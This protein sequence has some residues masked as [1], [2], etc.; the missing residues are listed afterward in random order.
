MLGSNKEDTKIK[1]SPED[2]DKSYWNKWYLAVLFFLIVQILIF[3]F[4]TQ[5]FN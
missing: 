3:Y 2:G 5:F 1:T 4:I